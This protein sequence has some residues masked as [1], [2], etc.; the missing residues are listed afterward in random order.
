MAVA[1]AT[2]VDFL[3]C[4]KCYFLFSF[5]YCQRCCQ[6]CWCRMS[7]S[8]IGCGCF[9]AI[10]LAQRLASSIN[11]PWPKLVRKGLSFSPPWH[12]IRLPS[13]H[14]SPA[15]IDRKFS[16][17]R[18]TMSLRSSNVS[19]AGEPPI[20]TSRKT[21]EMHRQT[22]VFVARE[23]GILHGRCI[24]PFRY[25]ARWMMLGDKHLRWRLPSGAISNFF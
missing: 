15:Q 16:A 5:R 11:V 9:H 1:V 23:R 21:C 14:R 18:G 8:H 3:Y 10:S 13:A 7:C 6:S 2:A 17:V 19:L 24:G 22:T 4:P 25:P 20:E 12:I